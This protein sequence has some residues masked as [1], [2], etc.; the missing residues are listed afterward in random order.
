MRQ[1]TSHIYTA[2]DQLD[3]SREWDAAA[4][5]T[6]RENVRAWLEKERPHL[7]RAYDAEF[8]VNAVESTRERQ[9]SAR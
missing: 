4:C 2:D 6:G 9:Q 1:D 5:G 8:L 3:L 7:L